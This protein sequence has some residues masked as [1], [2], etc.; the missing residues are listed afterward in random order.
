MLHIYEGLAAARQALALEASSMAEEES[1]PP[2]Q[3]AAAQPDEALRE[4]ARAAMAAGDSVFAFP[5]SA[6]LLESAGAAAQVN[7]GPG[8]TTDDDSHAV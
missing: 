4:A 8:R 7:H 3:E 1:E 2:Q 5:S 6:S